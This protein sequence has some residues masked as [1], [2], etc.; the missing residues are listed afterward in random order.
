MEIGIDDAKRANRPVEYRKLEAS[1]VT[2]T[3]AKSQADITVSMKPS[4][5][6]IK[7]RKQ[8]TPRVPLVSR[9]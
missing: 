2:I 7:C 4:V 8:G 6:R 3:A 1:Q 5:Q 9:K